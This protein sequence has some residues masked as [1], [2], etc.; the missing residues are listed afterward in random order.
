ME[1]KERSPK[2]L[3]ANGD[4]RGLEAADY[5]VVIQVLASSCGTYRGSSQKPEE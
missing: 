5:L 4:D 3:I 1:I 2:L